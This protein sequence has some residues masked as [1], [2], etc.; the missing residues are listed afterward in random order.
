MPSDELIVS[1]HLVK[2]TPCSFDL[3]N[4]VFSCSL[5]KRSILKIKEENEMM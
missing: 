2:G 3:F 4:H 1:F 5:N